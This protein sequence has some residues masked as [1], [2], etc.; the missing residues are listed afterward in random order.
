MTMSW[1]KQIQGIARQHWSRL[2]SASLK[3]SAEQASREQFVE[4]LA[5]EHKRDPI[6]K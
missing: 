2:T 6:H 3:R 1:G 4:W 5:R